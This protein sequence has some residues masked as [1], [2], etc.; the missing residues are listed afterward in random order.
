MTH[1]TGLERCSLCGRPLFGEVD[2]AADR[3]FM[4]RSCWENVREGRKEDLAKLKEHRNLANERGRLEGPGTTN[5]GRCGAV[6]VDER[7]RVLDHRCPI[8]PRGGKE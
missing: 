2:G 6:I 5:C 1:G 8:M 7:W 4:H 3:E